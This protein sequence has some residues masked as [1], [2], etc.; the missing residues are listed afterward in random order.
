M[1]PTLAM[2]LAGA[3]TMMGPIV[4]DKLF[5]YGVVLPAYESLKV[6]LLARRDARKQDGALVQAI[7][8]ALRQPGVLD[9][10]GKSRRHGSGGW[11]TWHIPSMTNYAN[12]W[13]AMLSSTRI[14]TIRCQ[15][16]CIWRY[17]GVRKKVTR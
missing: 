17:I 4:A 3:F 7:T 14:V 13:C 16:N 2:A 9:G 5:E 11:R 10:Q 12:W 8:E 1:D 15:R 6:R